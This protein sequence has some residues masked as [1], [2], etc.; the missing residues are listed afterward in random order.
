MKVKLSWYEN[1]WYYLTVIASFGIAY[2][3][4][5]IIKKA[6]EVKK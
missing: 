3:L 2:S 1:L 6:F 4:K 5:V